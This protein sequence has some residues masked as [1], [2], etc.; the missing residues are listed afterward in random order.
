M[1]APTCGNCGK[2]L[3]PP[4]GSASRFARSLITPLAVFAGV[5]WLAGWLGVT[6]QEEKIESAPAPPFVTELPPED[7][8]DETGSR[9]FP[10]VPALARALR[11]AGISCRLFLYDGSG[12]RESA[13]CG[14]P[15]KRMSLTVFLS[16]EVPERSFT[17]VR[18]PNIAL[19]GRNWTVVTDDRQ[20]AGTIERRFGA[21][22]R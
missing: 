13:T 5:I 15:G 6:L 22:R 1:D 12:R 4:L 18:E 3:R 2:D 19:V 14:S 21:R 16:R 11:G 8:I 7:I 20:I 17:A 9:R 10:S